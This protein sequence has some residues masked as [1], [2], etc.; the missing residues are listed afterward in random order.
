MAGNN[1]YRHTCHLYNN[2][3]KNNVHLHSAFQTCTF[4]RDFIKVVFDNKLR[5]TERDKIDM[6]FLNQISGRTYDS[7]KRNWSTTH[8]NSVIF[9][10]CGVGQT[11]GFLK[12]RDLFSVIR[13]KEYLC[14]GH[15]P[16][17]II[18]Q[19]VSGKPKLLMTY[20]E[21]IHHYFRSKIQRCL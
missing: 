10:Q 4:E 5:C 17:T 6:R 2:K 15:H 8:V 9:H 18:L 13:K 3:M 1:P 11:N 12:I 20:W 19:D 7:W 14:I 21:S 16:N